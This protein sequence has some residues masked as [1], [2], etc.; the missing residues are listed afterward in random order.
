M[1]PDKNRRI[2]VVDDT[3]SIHQD[4]HKILDRGPAVVDGLDALEE[5]LLGTAP[6]SR[7]TE[8]YD[9]R[10]AFSGEEACR[11]VGA[12]FSEGVRFALA[13]VD[14]RMPPGCDGV[15]T[16]EQLWR[17]D[18][19]I[20]I[21]ICTAY[22]D[23]SWE[24]ILDRVGASD[25]LLILKKP[26][27]NAEVCQLACA[28]TEKWQ[29]ARY[30]QLLL[31]QTQERLTR[32]QKIARAAVRQSQ[33]KSS[34]LASMSHELRTPLNAIIGYAELLKEEAG[35]TIDDHDPLVERHAAGAPDGD[36]SRILFASRHLLSLINDILDLAK[37][38]AGR[39]ELRAEHVGLPDLLNGVWVTMES[40]AR[41]NGTTLVFQDLSGRPTVRTDRTKL[42]QILLNLVSNAV[43]AA[44][45][46]HVRVT[47]S[48][49]DEVFCY[50][51][52]DDGVGMTPEVLAVL[53]DP[54]IQGP[55]QH[56]GTDS[57]GT[58]LGLTISRLLAELMGG[59]I[60]VTS[61]PDQGARFVLQLPVHLVDP[62]VRL[63]PTSSLSPSPT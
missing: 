56:R 44:P 63:R 28:L 19:D 48:A 9:V 43:R 16:I 24:E 27:D 18:P 17:I 54:Y 50:C 26:F 2:L 39:M 55:G 53:F 61:A 38:E 11:I 47:V 57:S 33:E 30:A 35:E 13:F 1:T 3:R 25:R 45:D 34:F 15:E 23:Y 6:Q 62:V 40:L 20:Q 8:A 5:S 14:M 12:A 21:V 52:E 37:V 22:S 49:T 7:P 46:G 31:T 60:T 4:F 10:S 41:A 42:R 59:E 29:L 58:G 32:Q 36:L 51:V